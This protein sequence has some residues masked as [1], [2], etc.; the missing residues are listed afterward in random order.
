MQVIK[1]LGKSSLSVD[2]LAIKAR[3]LGDSEFADL[4]VRYAIDS[5][6]KS[7]KPDISLPADLL[8]HLAE[9][10]FCS[11]SLNVLDLFDYKLLEF[12]GSNSL[13]LPSFGEI[14]NLSS[15][16]SGCWTSFNLR[17]LISIFVKGSKV[18]CS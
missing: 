14:V 13:K 17:T 11:G 7:L 6:V 12:L 16:E 9:M 1:L 15:G 5:N 2:K 4:C 18:I 3:Y 10:V 8:Y